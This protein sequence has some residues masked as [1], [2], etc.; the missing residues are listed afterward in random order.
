MTLLAH[1]GGMGWDEL[2]VFAAP[3]V[4]LAVMRVKNRRRAQEGVDPDQDGG[5]G[6]GED[7]EETA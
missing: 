1:A 4:V 3:V 2:L 6:H 7:D 5:D